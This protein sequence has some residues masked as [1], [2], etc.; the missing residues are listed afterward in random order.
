MTNND[1]E[2]WGIFE[3]ALQG[4]AEGNPF[5]QELLAKPQIL[6]IGTLHA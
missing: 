3:L 1:T 4:D 2:Q 6:L 5:V